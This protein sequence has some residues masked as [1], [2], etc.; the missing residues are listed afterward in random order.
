V[1]FVFVLAISKP[2][3]LKNAIPAVI[4]GT[5][6]GQVDYKLTFQPR[7]NTNVHS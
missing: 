2:P 7:I 5:N 6:W 3:N 4:G 1:K